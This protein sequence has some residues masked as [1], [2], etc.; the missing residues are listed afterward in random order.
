MSSDEDGSLFRHLDLA[1][2]LPACG[3]VSLRLEHTWQV[4]DSD[5]GVPSYVFGVMVGS[6]RAG[7][8][9]LRV[10]ESPTIRLYTGHLGYAIDEAFRGRLLS[11]AAARLVLPLAAAHGLDP[12]WI[13]CHPANHA[14]IRIIEALGA[15]YLETVDLPPDHPAF[16]NGERRKRRYALDLR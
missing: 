10:G 1:G 13:T 15:R 16:A 7:R 6:Q 14:S 8:V 4:A 12:L 11:L 9:T 2:A 3:D 5:W